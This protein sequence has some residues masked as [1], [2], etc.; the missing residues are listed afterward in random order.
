MRYEDFTNREN[1][2]G[3]FYEITIHLNE[4]PDDT[5]LRRA[6]ELVL[7]HPGV[8]GVWW[9]REDFGKPGVTADRIARCLQPERHE[10][11][12]PLDRL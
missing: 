11:R 5:R 12:T 7:S 10:T 3:S 4:G 8:K 2:N 1:W 9:K 6:L